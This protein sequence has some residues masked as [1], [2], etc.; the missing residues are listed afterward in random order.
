[1]AESGRVAGS[2]PANPDPE[3]GRSRA[4]SDSGLCKPTLVGFHAEGSQFCKDTVGYEEGNFKAV[5]QSDEDREHLPFVV[6]AA[7]VET[8]TEKEDTSKEL[9][10]SKIAERNNQEEEEEANKLQEEANDAQSDKD[11]EP[12]SFGDAAVSGQTCT[13]KEDTSK[14]LDCSKIVE[15]NTQEEEEEADKLQEE[16]NGQ[17]PPEDQEN[18][19]LENLDREIENAHVKEEKYQDIVTLEQEKKRINYLKEEC[20]TDEEN[21]DKSNAFSPETHEPAEKTQEEEDTMQKES[22]TSDTQK[23]VHETPDIHMTPSTRDENHEISLVELQATYRRTE[24]D[25]STSYS[26]LKEEDESSRD[27]EDSSTVSKEIGGNTDRATQSKTCPEDK[28]CSQEISKDNNEPDVQEDKTVLPREQLIFDKNQEIITSA[29]VELQKEGTTDAEKY[30]T[31]SPIQSTEEKCLLSEHQENEKLAVTAKIIQEKDQSH[32]DMELYEDSH[33]KKCDTLCVPDSQAERTSEKIGSE[34]EPSPTDP[35]EYDSLATT[36]SSEREELN[37]GA[38]KSSTEESEHI[39]DNEDENLKAVTQSDERDGQKLHN[40]HEPLSFEV[41]AVGNEEMGGSSSSQEISDDSSCLILSESGNNVYLKNHTEDISE[42]EASTKVHEV[43]STSEVTE[44]MLQDKENRE[45]GQEEEETPQECE[46]TPN[47]AKEIPIAQIEESVSKQS[48]NTPDRMD[49]EESVKV[50]SLEMVGDDI[51]KSTEIPLGGPGLSHEAVSGV[52][53]HTQVELGEAR[54]QESRDEVDGIGTTTADS[55]TSEDGGHELESCSVMKEQSIENTKKQKIEETE[56]PEPYPVSNSLFENKE[57]RKTTDEVPSMNNHLP[58]DTDVSAEQTTSEEIDEELVASKE[59]NKSSASDDISSAEISDEAKDIKMASANLLST[60]VL[61]TANAKEESSN[62]VVL[63]S[64][65]EAFRQEGHGKE[66]TQEFKLISSEKTKQ[67]IISNEDNESNSKFLEYHDETV[68]LSEEIDTEG[69]RDKGQNK[70]PTAE[71]PPDGTTA[72]EVSNNFEKSYDSLIEVPKDEDTKDKLFQ[73]IPSF[74]I[75][76]EVGEATPDNRK[77]KQE[78]GIVRSILYNETT[79]GNVSLQTVEEFDNKSVTSSGKTESNEDRHGSISQEVHVLTASEVSNV[80]ACNK[81]GIQLLDA[82]ILVFNKQ[83]KKADSQEKTMREKQPELPPC[84]QLSGAEKFTTGER[85]VMKTTEDKSHDLANFETLQNDKDEGMDVSYLPVSQ[86]LINR[87]M[88]EEDEKTQI[89]VQEGIEDGHEG[90]D[91]MTKELD[92]SSDKHERLEE[93]VSQNIDRE[94]KS[95]VSSLPAMEI[96]VEDTKKEVFW[97]ENLIDTVPKDDEKRATTEKNKTQSEL[98]NGEFMGLGPKTHE[99][100]DGLVEVMEQRITLNDNKVL[101]K[102]PDS[103]TV[104]EIDSNMIPEEKCPKHVEAIEKQ[105][106]IQMLEEMEQKIILNDNKALTK[107]PDSPSVAEVDGNKIPQ[108]ENCP[109]YVEARGI[110]LNIQMLEE[111]II[112]EHPPETMVT[113]E[114]KSFI[115]IHENLLKTQEPPRP[116]LEVNQVLGDSLEFAADIKEVKIIENKHD[117]ISD[118]QV[119]GSIGKTKL[120]HLG[121]AHPSD[122][123]KDPINRNNQI[124]KSILEEKA[125]ATNRD[126][127]NKEVTD[128]QVGLDETKNFNGTDETP[129]K[130]QEPSTPVREVNQVV[131]DALDFAPAEK[132]IKAQTDDKTDGIGDAQMDSTVE[133]PNR[134][135]KLSDKK[136]PSESEEDSIDDHIQIAEGTL[137]EKNLTINRD[138]LDKEPIH[139]QR[140]EDTG[141]EE[142]EKDVEEYEVDKSGADAPMTVETWDEEPKTAHKKPHNILSGVKSK[143]K[144]S[145]AKVKKAITGKSSHSKT[146]PTK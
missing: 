140:D 3:S 142:V 25:E 104:A 139:M 33:A 74:T 39:A 63:M 13:E 110:Q 44:E 117:G 47:T 73:D 9:D 130:I 107:N 97:S 40:H 43:A 54:G 49:S 141:D 91:I 92:I 136:H 86:Y 28:L 112:E 106:N 65:G 114:M 12:L 24:E 134:R 58:D 126:E 17:P 79:A 113:T 120:S 41:N 18:I 14:E 62:S 100:S 145:I 60:N 45:K 94:P 88:R 111:A 67:N 129:L 15:T 135:A 6:V 99:K 109:K 8:C 132:E 68:D 30:E 56:L 138:G 103:P 34:Y 57:I 59:T 123:E 82:S 115:G 70:S 102:K 105:S 125:L 76:M 35:Q 131:Q 16:A 27:Q 90:V 116:I 81:D 10:F 19:K 89:V 46:P 1:M 127:L 50:T 31:S 85:E 53:Q 20:I 23:T 77:E 118:V 52:K 98:K 51:K 36:E 96:S 22:P 4:E 124:A 95:K 87:I 101:T 11:H 72:A 108:E 37:Q 133:E 83:T 71:L 5:A 66:Q 69:Y 78:M 122:S 64:L 146:A 32:R 144:H 2:A 48:R 75:A 143:V 137:E 29:D 121:E 128:M 38:P 7:S 80:M 42:K 21:P 119:E 84:K 26:Q 55:E 61:D 93:F